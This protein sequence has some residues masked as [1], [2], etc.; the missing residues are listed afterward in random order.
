MDSFCSCQLA[1][2]SSF[3][4]ELSFV[5]NEVELLHFL[6]QLFGVR[7]VCVSSFVNFGFVLVVDLVNLLR[8][9]FTFLLLISG[10]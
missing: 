10:W 6:Y 3:E 7:S 8:I 5:F 9:I 1:G 2:E 4:F